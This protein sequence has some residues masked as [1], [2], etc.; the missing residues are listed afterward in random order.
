MFWQENP[1]LLVLDSEV[2]STARFQ[3]VYIDLVMDYALTFR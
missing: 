2:H 1:S 3:W